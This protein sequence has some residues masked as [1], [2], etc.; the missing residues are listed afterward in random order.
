[1]RPSSNDDRYAIPT[2]GEVIAEAEGQ[3][4]ALAAFCTGCICVGVWAITVAVVN[5]GAISPLTPIKKATLVG[6][7]IFGLWLG[8]RF[9]T[10]FWLLVGLSIVAGAALSL[11][12]WIRS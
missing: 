1:M 12:L 9:A 5:D 3:A 11:V 2:R 10:L 7:A 6:S 8:W 4:K